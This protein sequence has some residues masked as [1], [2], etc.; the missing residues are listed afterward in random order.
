MTPFFFLKKVFINHILLIIKLY[1][2]KSCEKKFISINNFT[3]EIRKVKRIEKEIALTKSKKTIAFTKKWY[4][5]IN[6]IPQRR[7]FVLA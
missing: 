2:F 3:A 5:I 7:R 1:V 4:I 6:I